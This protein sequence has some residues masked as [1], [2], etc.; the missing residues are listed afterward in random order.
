M[1]RLVNDE[2]TFM[3]FTFAGNTID[4]P[5]II[6][7]EPVFGGFAAENGFFSIFTDP[8]YR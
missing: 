1:A 5:L 6:E 2:S 3:R 8:E 4:V 7:K